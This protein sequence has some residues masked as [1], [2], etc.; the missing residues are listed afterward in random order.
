MDYGAWFSNFSCV[1]CAGLKTYV[2]KGKTIFWSRFQVEVDLE[3]PIVTCIHVPT[4]KC[5]AFS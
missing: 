3:F 4:K 5:N 1:V 2:V